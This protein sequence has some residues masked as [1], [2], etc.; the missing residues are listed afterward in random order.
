MKKSLWSI[1][2]V[3]LTLVIVYVVGVAYF[4][5]RF[6]PSTSLASVSISGKTL[7]QAQEA[8]VQKFNDQS[9]EVMENNQNLGQV[10]IQDLQ[11]QY[12]MQQVLKMAFEKQNPNLWFTYFF[13]PTKIDPQFANTVTVDSAKLESVFTKLGI[14]NEKRKD[15]T[16]ATIE[17][18]K[19]K[20][21]FVKAEKI[22]TKVDFKKLALAAMD[23]V[24][25]QADELDLTSGY[26]DPAVK[27][28][29]KVVTDTMKQIHDVAESKITLTIA[30]DEV[31]IPKEVI[32]DWIHFDT[33][34]QMA[35]SPEGITTYLNQLNEKYS[36]INKVR[37]IDSA[38][39]GKVEVQPGILGWSIDTEKETQNIIR[40]LFANKPVKRDPAIASRGGIPNAKD[41]IGSTYIEVDL[42]NQ[43][44]WYYVDKKIV[45]ETPIV[46]GQPASPSTPGAF[47]IIEKLQNTE[48]KGYNPFY[49]KKYSV[50]VA[51]WMRFNDNAEGIHDSSWQSSYGG[52]TWQWSGSLGCIN[53]PIDAVATIY[54]TADYGT[55]VLV[56]H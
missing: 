17:Y 42:T 24:G 2:G 23:G 32:M 25:N 13:R 28:T 40:D 3:V 33:N 5:N 11:A 35:F 8:F 56:H 18:D 46:S 26:Q 47:A 55:P 12:D 44:M 22:G 29:S 34:G 10:K 7:D 14:D 51:Y 6:M 48:L 20:G 49:K 38:M 54:A 30:G 21:Y 52:N 15:G 37:T 39:Q 50:P 27:S 53:T 4:A 19:A 31:K 45:V 41:D 43:M 36:T 9:I 1:I 16:N